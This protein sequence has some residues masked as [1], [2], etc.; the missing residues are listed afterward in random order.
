MNSNNPLQ[1]INEASERTEANMDYEQMMR[2]L[3]IIRQ[4]TKS[5]NDKYKNDEQMSKNPQNEDYSTINNR[6]TTIYNTKSVLK[7][8]PNYVISEMNNDNRS[9]NGIQPLKQQLNKSYIKTLSKTASKK[10][11]SDTSTQRSK[12]CFKKYKTWVIC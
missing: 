10:T 5:D 2:T 3:E 12:L 9:L 4:K 6:D 11:L 8:E 7:S 1:V